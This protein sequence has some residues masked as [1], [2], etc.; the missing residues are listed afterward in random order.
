MQNWPRWLVVSLLALSFL[1]FFFLGGLGVKTLQEKRGLEIA[2]RETAENLHSKQMRIEELK[3][4]LKKA[5]DRKLE[6]VLEAEHS[7][8]AEIRFL[9][10]QFNELQVAKDLLEEENFQQAEKIDLQRQRLASNFDA[11]AVSYTHLTLP[12]TP[13]V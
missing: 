11:I 6:K 8:D 12:T 7:K 4:N 5:Q 2:L 9:K 13:Y 10:S 3:M 1:L